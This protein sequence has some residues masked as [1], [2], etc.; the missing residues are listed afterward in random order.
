MKTRTTTLSMGRSEGENVVCTWKEQFFGKILFQGRLNMEDSLSLAILLDKVVSI[1]EQASSNTL[2]IIS[3]KVLLTPVQFHYQSL[4][5]LIN[6]PSSFLHENLVSWNRNKII[7]PVSQAHSFKDCIAS[8]V[9]VAF[10]LIIVQPKKKSWY[11]HTVSVTPSS[12]VPSY[13]WS[14]PWSNIIKTA[15]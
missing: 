14:M 11:R 4:K 1:T 5:L 8:S 15:P 13:R 9:P 2:I 6:T 7:A 12:C 10:S 3:P